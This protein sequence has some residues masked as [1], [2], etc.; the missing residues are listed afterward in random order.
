MSSPSR[1]HTGRGIPAIQ[2]PRIFERFWEAERGAADG[3]GLVE[4]QGGRICVQ[5]EEGRGT[6]FFF[7]LSRRP[8]T[9]AR[10]A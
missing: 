7:T 4:A 10:A 8:G 9:V 3:L 2:L 5:S 6:T 1:V